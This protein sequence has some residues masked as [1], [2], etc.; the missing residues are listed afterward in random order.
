MI[1]YLLLIPWSLW[2]QN[3]QLSGF[4]YD[5]DTKESLFSAQIYIPTLQKGCV[6]DK[7]GYYEFKNLP[8]GRYKVV[9][10]YMGY[11]SIIR[12]IDLSANKI[13]YDVALQ[14]SYLLSEEIVISSGLASTQH[15]NAI[16][17]ESIS[18]QQL[19]TQAG[20]NLVAKLSE[21]PGVNML[22]KGNAVVSPVIRGLSTSNIIM[23]N[24]GI[25]LENYQFSANH[26]YMIDEAGISK[27]EVIKG[28][29][30]LL[31]GS[32]AIGG[33]I[34]VI[35]ENP[36]S[37]NNIE[38]DAHINYYSNTQGLKSNL[39]IKTSGENFIWGLRASQKSHKDY[40]QANGQRVPNSRFNQQAIHAFSG[41]H[42]SKASF[43]IYYDYDAMKLGLITAKSTKLVQDNKRQN[44]QW[45]QDLH[46][47]VLISK[48]QFF[49]HKWDLQ[50]NW[51][52]QNNHRVL[53][54]SE[55]ELH[56]VATDMRLQ[57]F[58]YE[59]KA[60]IELAEN[61]QIIMGYQGMLQNNKNED[62][63]QHVLPDYW[64]KDHS[65][66]M[67][68]QQ[69]IHQKTHI[70]MGLRYDYRQID[71]PN[72][73]NAT[74]EF[75]S[76]N[77]QYNNISASAG[78]TQQINSYLLIRFNMASAYRIP[79][80]AELSQDGIHANR[81]EIGDANLKAQRN[82]EID[83][84]THYHN[85]RISLD[86]ALFYNQ[87]NDF[88]FLSPTV[89]TT[90]NGFNIYKY[91]QTNAH[92][93]GLESNIAYAPFNWVTISSNYSHLVSKQENG[94]YL[95]FIPQDNWQLSF[96]WQKK[97]MGKWEQL[98]FE[99]KN[100]YVFTQNHPAL[101]ETKTQAYFLMH[102]SIG[103]N[104]RINNRI[105]KGQINIQNA[106]NEEYFDH[107]SSLKSLG[108]YNIGRQI[109]LSIKIPFGA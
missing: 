40:Y 82:Y 35:P 19:D 31:Y 60:P 48:N 33:V 58:N 24:N 14:E 77:K 1:L 92:I 12:T 30:S 59:V 22:S 87:I 74:Q 68:Y 73:T 21:T 55:K 109:M 83:W 56:F 57:T 96:K 16:K 51:S 67:L 66:F 62:A 3:Y 49:F 89:D 76:I 32:N 52:Y 104:L 4:V 100:E 50:A 11:T 71:I 7:N 84:S 80:I 25:R 42:K 17:I 47:H 29:A 10:K 95:P 41:W 99:W 94:S 64:Q 45:Y 108:Y 8:K 85:N 107:L 81:Y 18:A 38:V 103:A 97:N 102:F 101:F 78:L 26:P 36:A 72:Q 15:E 70:Q 93:Y 106:L 63:P 86:V 37:A 27:V 39:G 5:K 44:E 34:N 2:A 28:P 53:N 79:N 43:K 54:T 105:I 98:F 61:K 6:S 75:T 46:N 13:N 9:F 23:L 88:I 90:L 65:I 20:L 91:A 69:S